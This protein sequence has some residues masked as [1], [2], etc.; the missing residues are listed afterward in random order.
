MGARSLLLLVWLAA[1]LTVAGLQISQAEGGALS[2]PAD[3]V[4]V[5]HIAHAAGV[6]LSELRSGGAGLEDEFLALVQP[7]PADGGAR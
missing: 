4:Q 6:A 1:A 2:V 3:P 5:G 7:E